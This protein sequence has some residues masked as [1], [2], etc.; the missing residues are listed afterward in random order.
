MK[1]LIELLKD[2][3]DGPLVIVLVL[4]GLALL[5]GCTF[6]TSIVEGFSNCG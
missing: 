3:G 2:N 1:E 6:L 5:M 4:G